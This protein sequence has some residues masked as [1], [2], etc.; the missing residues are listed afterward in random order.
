[1]RSTLTIRQAMGAAL[2]LCACASN[3][4]VVNSWRDP[5][6][7]PRRFN[8]VLAVFISTD[9]RVRR[10]AEDQLGGKL[11][12]AVP[13]YTVIPDSILRDRKKAKAWVRQAGFDGAVIMRSVRVDQ[14]TTYVP[15]QSY[16]VPAGYGS[17]W[18]YWE[19]SWGFAQDPGYVQ[20]DQVVSVEGNVYSVADDKL[21]WASRTKTYHPESVGQLVDEIVDVTVAEMKRQK[22][23]AS[24]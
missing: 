17:M 11:G 9:A 19:T 22:V 10:A 1:M 2:L 12:N 16:V 8:K 14:E 21:I 23:M 3:T 24:R 20:K 5:T 7:V 13:A 6:V 4:E 18:G 15:G